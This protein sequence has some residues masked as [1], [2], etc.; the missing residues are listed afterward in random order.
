LIGKNAAGADAV[1]HVECLGVGVKFLDL[2]SAA[3]APLGAE[4]VVGG[5][6][7]DH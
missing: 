2:V 6:V 3:D 4:L 1:R 7:Q 5:L